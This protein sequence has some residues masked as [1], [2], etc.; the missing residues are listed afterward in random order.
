VG[1]EGEAEGSRAIQSSR[2]KLCSIIKSTTANIQINTLCESVDTLDLDSAFLSLF[3]SG[4]SRRR[5]ANPA[6]LM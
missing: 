1:D 6:A 5:R 3:M 2:E 4:S